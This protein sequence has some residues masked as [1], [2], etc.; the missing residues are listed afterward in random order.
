MMDAGREARLET[1]AADLR[2]VAE[3]RATAEERE[4]AEER[5][6]LSRS[7]LEEMLVRKRS[8]EFPRS[9]T[10]RALSGNTP[11]LVTGVAL[12]LLAVKPR[13]GV[14]VLRLLPILRMLNRLTR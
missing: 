6:A 13:W 10:M 8:T 4:A 2:E 12:G 1:E 11:L 9:R 3:E 14:R 7:E 5:M